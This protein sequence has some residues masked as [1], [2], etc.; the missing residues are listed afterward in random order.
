MFPKH[1]S[2]GEE[3]HV[4]EEWLRMARQ[5]VNEIENHEGS[6]ASFGARRAALMRRISYSQLASS[7]R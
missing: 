1:H 5:N 4:E 3:E 7:K 6:A 2:E